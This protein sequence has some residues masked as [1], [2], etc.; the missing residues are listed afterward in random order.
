MK[1]HNEIK[2]INT[3]FIISKCTVLHTIPNIQL[4]S[5]MP[6]AIAQLLLK[7]I[8]ILHSHNNIIILFNTNHGTAKIS[9]I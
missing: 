4:N 3:A 5:L 2:Y 9:S 1:Y 8:V 6:A 7:I